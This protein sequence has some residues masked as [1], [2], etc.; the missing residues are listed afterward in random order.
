MQP[1][2]AASG[3]TSPSIHDRRRSARKHPHRNHLMAKLLFLSPQ[4]PRWRHFARANAA[5]PVQSPDWL[6]ALISAYGLTAQVVALAG[7]DDALVAGLPMIRNNLPWTRKW[8]SLPFTDTFEPIALNKS[9]RDELLAAMPEVVSAPILI[10]THVPLPGWFSRQVGTVQVID[11][12][13]GAEGV[14]HSAD[15]KTRRNVKRAQR[16]DAGLTA[17]PITSRSEFMGASL[18]LMTRS[19]R[20]LGAP[21]QP[22]RYWSHVWELHERDKAL[23]IG[24]YIGNTLVANGVFIVGRKHAVYKYS[25]S[26]PAAWKLRTNYLMLA[27]ALD[28]IAARGVLSMDFGITELRNTSLREYKARWGGEQRPARFSATDARL[29]P[30]TLEPGRLLTQT[31]QHTPA[32]VGRTVGALGYRFVA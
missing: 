2:S 21:T 22:R 7:M 18:T 31:I 24:V 16:P 25:A 9:H 30:E 13:D 23:T 29:L 5:S 20:R 11:L 3:T 28:H 8:T 27:T 1:C 17:R 12:S 6:H 4:D 14:L 32:F 26:D 15:P 19:R 10:R